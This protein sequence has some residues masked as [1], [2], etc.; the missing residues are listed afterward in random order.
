MD[1]FKAPRSEDHVPKGRDTIVTFEPVMVSFVEPSVPV[2]VFCHQQGDGR[3]Q[4]HRRQRLPRVALDLY[5]ITK[6]HITIILQA[7]LSAAILTERENIAS[8]QLHIQFVRW[9]S[10]DRLDSGNRKHE[11]DERLDEEVRN[12]EMIVRLLNETINKTNYL[13]TSQGVTQNTDT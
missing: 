5:N 12:A 13:P 10:S 3:K 1:L 9:L 7:Y 11:R 8:H 4:C 6:Q 2:V